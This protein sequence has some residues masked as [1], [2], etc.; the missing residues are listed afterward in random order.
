MKNSIVIIGIVAI[1]FAAGGFFGGMKY[2][3]TKT[4]QFNRGQF[5]NGSQ[6]GQ[7]RN[8]TG[9][10]MVNG[11]IL[12]VDTTSMTVKLQDNSS[13]IVILSGTTTYAKS[14]QGA[15]TDLVVGE[16]VSAFGTTNADGSV[17]A[18]SIQINPPQG[19][20]GGV[21]PTPQK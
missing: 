13:K 19:R 3:Q 21:N 2:Q 11:T 10:G 14:T 1:A 16:R 5:V 4:P 6:N 20:I 12:S 8:R 7:A 17:T 18:Q 9:G 15:Q